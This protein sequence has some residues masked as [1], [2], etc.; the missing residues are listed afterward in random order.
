MELIDSQHH[1]WFIASLLPH[2]RISLLQHNIGMQVE[3]LEIM[4]RLHATPIQDT[5]F[6]LQ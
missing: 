1:K 2:M 5:T 4:M 3:A 6:G